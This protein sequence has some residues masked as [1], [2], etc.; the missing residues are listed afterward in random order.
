LKSWNLKGLKGDGLSFS[1][2][3]FILFP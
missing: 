3:A 2:I 1:I